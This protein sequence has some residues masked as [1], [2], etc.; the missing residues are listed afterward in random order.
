ME[1]VEVNVGVMDVPVDELVR[2]VVE[3]AFRMDS[4]T[5]VQ[6]L[7]PGLSEIISMMSLVA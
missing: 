5:S 6:E 1:V 2:V 7:E 4:D 3:I